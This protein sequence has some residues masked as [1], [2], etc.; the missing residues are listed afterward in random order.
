M[1]STC[2]GDLDMIDDEALGDMISDQGGSAAEGAEQSS[3][4]PPATVAKQEPAPSIPTIKADADSPE[5]LEMMNILFGEEG[6][7][8]GGQHHTASMTQDATHMQS[9]SDVVRCT[10]CASSSTDPD[11]SDP[12]SQKRTPFVRRVAQ[13]GLLCD[14][15]ELL[16]R[17]NGPTKTDLGKSDTLA[18]TAARRDHIKR[19]SC[20]L[21]LKAT[22]ASALTVASMT[23]CSPA[24]ACR[25]TPATRS[26]CTTWASA[27]TFAAMATP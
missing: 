5:D 4:L 9:Q 27:T 8:E 16:I 21:A 10:F 1:V 14:H 11:L 19:L 17:Y 6:A 3:R 12:T 2:G 25:R 24:R 7:E 26:T 13:R 20:Y 18:T 23:R 22:E 15:C